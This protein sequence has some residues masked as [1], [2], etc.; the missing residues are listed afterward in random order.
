[1]F[2]HAS[3]FIA[4]AMTDLLT[5]GRYSSHFLNLSVYDRSKEDILFLLPESENLDTIKAFKEIDSSLGDKE[6]LEQNLNSL[7]EMYSKIP[8]NSSL[9]GDDVVLIQSR[10]CDIYKYFELKSQNCKITN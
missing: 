4:G 10:I 5:V 1:M 8:K 7:S 3:R 9:S 6:K 2:V